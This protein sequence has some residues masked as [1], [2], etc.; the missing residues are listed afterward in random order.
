M[1]Y[2]LGYA[3]YL[4]IGAAFLLAIVVGLVVSRIRRR[5]R[6]LKQIKTEK[7]WSRNR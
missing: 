6:I 7:V 2:E 1:E 5:R 3:A 4:F